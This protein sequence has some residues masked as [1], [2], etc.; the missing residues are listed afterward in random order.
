MREPRCGYHQRIFGGFKRIVGRS[1]V[2]IAVSASAASALA[3]AADPSSEVNGGATARSPATRLDPPGRSVSVIAGGDVLTESRVRS[4]AATDGAVTGLRFDFGPM[5]GELRPVIETADLAICHME[6]PVGAPGGPYGYA[7]RSPFG[8]NRLLAP[9]EVAEGLRDVGFDRCSTASNHSND[10]GAPGI[11]STIDALNSV[12]IS[13][14]GTARSVDEAAVTGFEVN[15]VEVAHLSYTTYSNTVLPAEWWR[16]NHTRNPRR[17]ADAVDAARRSGVE[18]VLLSLHV[19]T[20]LQP[21]PTPG[22]RALI[23]SLTAMADVD[24][25]FVHGPH[26]VQPFEFV[27]GT[28]VWWSLG[29]FVSEM[30]PPSVGRYASPRTSDGLLAF[31]RFEEQPAGGFSASPSS[32]AICND[33]SDRTVRSATIGLARPDLAGRVHTELAQCLSRTRALVPS[34]M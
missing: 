9:Y 14:V 19:S 4:A 23:A 30:G 3:H 11:A 16:V 20:E 7:G 1:A 31:V 12:G 21:A 28:P 32:V 34:A 24:A 6:I 29:N 22:D 10:V 26:V 18:L 5:F 2:A 8:G 17:I 33:F 15:R 13:V 25:V 27:N